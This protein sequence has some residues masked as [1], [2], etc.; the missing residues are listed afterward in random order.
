MASVD[1]TKDFKDYSAEEEARVKVEL[2]MLREPRQQAH[3]IPS[4]PVFSG[5]DAGKGEDYAT[6]RHAVKGLVGENF[7]ND[8]A[9]ATAIR[10]STMG[11]AAQVLRNVDY[12]STVEV[13]LD[14]LDVI[15]GDII[16]EAVTWSQFYNARQTKLETIVAWYTRLQDLLRR[17]SDRDSTIPSK[18]KDNMLKNQLWSN[19][20]NCKQKE[21]S[22][23]KYDESGTAV[24][25]FKYLR[26]WKEEENH[27]SKTRTFTQTVDNSEVEQLKKRL[28]E[29]ELKVEQACKNQ[30]EQDLNQPKVNYQGQYQGYQQ[31]TQYR[32]QWNRYQPRQQVNYWPRQQ[33]NYQPRHQQNYQP[34]QPQQYQ[35]SQQQYQPWQQQ[36]YQGVQ[37]HDAKQQWQG[38][39]VQGQPN[40]QYQHQAT[41]YS[42]YRNQVQNSQ[43]G[44]KLC[45]ICGQPG[46]MARN[47]VV[48]QQGRDSAN[49]PPQSG[50][51]KRHGSAA[52]PMRQ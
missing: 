17:A 45:Y 48:G 25:L 36:H 10:K 14:E 21:A 5:E 15:Y 24:A 23:H 27:D 20:Y 12:G 44:S 31:Q 38:H 13:L 40:Q 51:D 47:C 41:G 26:L 9:V 33:Q 28:A 29:M 16:T 1:I 37:Q 30:Q 49:S 22:R 19:L 8:N 46:H 3:R 11:Q 50:N 35:P 18:T 2:G 39:E 4:L 32:P 42:D 52:N 6:W 7:Y 34:R 43:Q